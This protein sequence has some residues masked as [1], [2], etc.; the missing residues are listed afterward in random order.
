MPRR[1][2]IALFA[3]LAAAI[4]GAIV[5]IAVRGPAILLDLGNIVCF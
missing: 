4:L 1:L 2:K 3:I 5:L